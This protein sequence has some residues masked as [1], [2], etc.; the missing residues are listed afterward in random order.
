[1]LR[2]QIKD[3]TFD[4]VLGEAKVDNQTATGGQ[5][6]LDK[7]KP[8]DKGTM[9]ITTSLDIKSTDGDIA[10]CSA[11]FTGVG[12]LE[13]DEIVTEHIIINVN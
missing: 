11:S 4:F 8:Y 6:E 2:R 9:V 3:E 5:F 10:T 12:A 1:M 7:S 13:E